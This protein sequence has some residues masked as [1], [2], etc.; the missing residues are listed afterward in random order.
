MV[1]VELSDVFVTIGFM[2]CGSNMPIVEIILYQQNW[3]K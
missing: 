2:I 1:S 3:P